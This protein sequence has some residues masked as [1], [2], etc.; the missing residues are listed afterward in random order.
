MSYRA[1]SGARVRTLLANPQMALQVCAVLTEASSRAR[2]LALS[3]ARHE[4]E[5]RIGAFL[6]DIYDRL[7]RR[8]L[9]DQPAFPLPLT[10]AQ[11]ADH[12]G[13]TGVHVNRTLAQLRR[14]RLVFIERGLA[15]IHDVPGLRE[16][17]TAPLT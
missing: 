1:I 3:I 16:L 9:I 10:Q 11:I 15:T 6:L 2:R 4:A 13:L 8:G 7:S 5:A 14:A 12:L 17:I